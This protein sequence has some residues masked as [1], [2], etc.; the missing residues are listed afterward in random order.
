MKKV[1]E[2]EFHKVFHTEADG[3]VLI[4]AP[5]GDAASFRQSDVVQ[6]LSTLMDLA[7]GDRY[8]HLVVDLEAEQYFGS[9]MVGA[10][11]S[12]TQRVKERGGKAV[13]CN[14]SDT[15][16]N[17]LQRLKMTEIWQEAETPKDALREVRG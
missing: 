4:V 6:E 8:K 12:L 11:Q 15:M 5:R 7:G 17:M 13:L 16:R 3:D 10:I 14:V 2:T 1:A 9:T